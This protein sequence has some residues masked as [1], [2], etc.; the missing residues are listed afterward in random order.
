MMLSIYR[1]TERNGVGCC[2]EGSGIG[3]EGENG[4]MSTGSG[5]TEEEKT[6]EQKPKIK[7]LEKKAET[8]F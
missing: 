2:R 3:T 4:A 5:Q 6:K 7:R 8:G 1:V